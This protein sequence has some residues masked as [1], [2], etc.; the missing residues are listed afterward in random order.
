MSYCPKCDVVVR[1]HKS[2]CPLCQGKVSDIPEGRDAFGTAGTDAFPVIERRISSFTFVRILTFLFLTLEICFGAVW[3]L[4]GFDAPW[5]TLVMLGIFV[6]WLDVLATIYIRR[7]LTKLFTV[8]V[9]VA[10]AVNIYVDHMTNMHGWSLS[11]VAPSLLFALGLATQLIALTAKLRYNEYFSYLALDALV[12]LGQLI[13]I[14]MGLNPLP[15]PA[16]ICIACYLILMAGLVVFRYRE[17]KTAIER[18]ISM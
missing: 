11:W 12:S 4:L 16:I 15:I 5:V 13:P 9:Y 18:R 6:G 2:C 10:I 1:G 3:W 17:L 7:N 14:R 8:E